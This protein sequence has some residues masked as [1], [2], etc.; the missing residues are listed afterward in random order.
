MVSGS[1]EAVTGSGGVCGRY[2]VMGWI[3]VCGGQHAVMGCNRVVIMSTEKSNMYIR[4]M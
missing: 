1:E 2:A 3:R 4:S